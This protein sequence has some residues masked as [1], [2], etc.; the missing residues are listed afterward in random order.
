MHYLK[1]IMILFVLLTQATSQSD[2]NQSQSI[3]Y[4]AQT[5][6]AANESKNGDLFE[7]NREKY[8][9][10]VFSASA[11]FTIFGATGSSINNVED[12][13]SVTPSQNGSSSSLSTKASST[14]GLG[15]NIS[16]RGGYRFNKVASLYTGVDIAKKGY[17]INIASEGSET[18][19]YEESGVALEIPFFFRPI[20]ATPNG[21]HSFF[22]GVGIAPSF[23][24]NKKATI[25]VD[26][27]GLFKTSNREIIKSEEADVSVLLYDSYNPNIVIDSID[28]D[29]LYRSF[30]LNMLLSLGVEKKINSKV[31]FYGCGTYRH[32]LLSE[33]RM[34]DK[35]KDK[36]D[37]YQIPFDEKVKKYRSLEFSIG[38]L[39]YP[40]SR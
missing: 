27:S 12:N 28:Y 18:L 6:E 14:V 30:D 2:S 34:T 17:R 1:P 11:G 40:K 31:S 37:L 3:K 5:I 32:G 25:Y 36:L 16:V 23:L 8:K 38:L 7:G 33:V 39:F 24:L 29:A 21:I 10:A 20:F 35:A 22:L 4:N 19:Y 26:K 15:G 13:L 9:G